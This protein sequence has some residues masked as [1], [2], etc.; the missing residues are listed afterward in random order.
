MKNANIARFCTALLFPVL[1]ANAGVPLAHCRKNDK[2][3]SG[4]QGEVTAA[5]VASGKN[6]VGF[7]C[8]T[9][10]VGQ[11]QGEGASWQLTAWKNCAYFDQRKG[12][13]LAHPGTVAV[14]VTDP[15]HP[16]ATAWLD[17]AAMLDPWESLKINPARQLLAGDQGTIGTP[18]P[19]FAVY[20]VSGDCR[21]PVK[22]AFVNIPASLGHTGQWA[23]DGKT[24][25][26][27][28]IA[29]TQA[30]MVAVDVTDPADPKQLLAYTPPAGINPVYHDLEFSK[31]GNTA[32]VTAIGGLGGTNPNGLIIFDVSDIQS[33]KQN[34][35][36][37]IIS[38]FFWDDGSI[39]AQ[40]ALPVTIAGKPYII[41]TDEAGL[42]S[43][44]GSCTAGK[45]G[46]GYPHILDIT[47]PKNP[48]LAATVQMDV[49]DPL[50]CQQ[51]IAL[52]MTSGATSI[53]GY[54][55]HYCAVDDP[56]DAKTLACNCF[57][58]GLRVFDISN[59]KAI[60]EIGYFKPPAQGTKVLPGSQYANFNAPTFDRPIDWASSKPSF[61]KDRGMTT[62]D[63]WTTSQDNGFMVVKLDANAR[64]TSGSGC[65][66]ADGSLGGM[67]VLAVMEILRRRRARASRS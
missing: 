43:F 27:T 54:S 51:S 18:G 12:S 37:R 14:D 21:H 5:E 13:N 45:S 56:D 10:L 19:G 60:R 64:A 22:K 52:K 36:I 46:Q 47:D 31:D 23:P 39:V 26:I 48:K 4:L 59:V 35:Q 3:E 34:P 16:V 2:T 6:K 61:P 11:Y 42:A 28:T 38:Q 30:A 32:Y 44:S 24:Y 9:D 29:Q 33:R 41:F 20:D 49:A 40:N 50:S 55:C 66:S 15:A 62:G 7:N 65:A 53:F 57:A 17:D 8:N 67:L 58:A 1:A 63:L 25:Y